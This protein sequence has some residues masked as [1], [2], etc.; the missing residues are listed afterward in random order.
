M[1][2]DRRVQAKV[3]RAIALAS[4]RKGGR[5]KAL[6]DMLAEGTSR[7]QTPLGV[8]LQVLEE[9]YWSCQCRQYALLSL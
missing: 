2:D 8:R 7:N 3:S 1:R 4:S 5:E 6:T 9:V